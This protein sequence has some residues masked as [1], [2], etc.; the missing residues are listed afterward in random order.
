MDHPEVKDQPEAIFTITKYNILKN[1]GA[2]YT[3]DSLDNETFENIQLMTLCMSYEAKA[4]ENAQNK[5]Q[6]VES[7]MR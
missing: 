3:F 6:F 4:M 2:S 7:S 1:L 5:A